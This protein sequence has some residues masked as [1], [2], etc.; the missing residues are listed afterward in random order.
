MVLSALSY[1]E[2]SLILEEIAEDEKV[3]PKLLS[4]DPQELVKY[5]EPLHV[6]LAARNDDEV[7]LIL[8]GQTAHALA[9]GI[10][11]VAQIF[12]PAVVVL[13]GAMRNWKDMVEKAREIYKNMLGVVPTVPVGISQLDNAGIVG[14]AALAFE[15]LNH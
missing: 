4:G 10:R 6:N 2:E 3:K 9:Y 13:A 12:D 14:S 1:G 5:I 8:E 15:I 7:A 11:N